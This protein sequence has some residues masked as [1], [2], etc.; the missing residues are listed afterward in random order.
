MMVR[1]A[2]AVEMSGGRNDAHAVARLA[3]AINLSADGANAG[4]LF[5]H[6][7]V[8][9]VRSGPDHNNLENNLMH[10]SQRLFSQRI[11]VFT[12]FT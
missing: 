9:S 6:A 1:P 7:N 5:P 3:D 12:N 2:G 4:R 11:S 10:S 8:K